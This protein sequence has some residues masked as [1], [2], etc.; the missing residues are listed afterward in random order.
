MRQDEFVEQHGEEAWDRLVKPLK[1]IWCRCDKCSVLR[2]NANVLIH[3]SLKNGESP[4]VYNPHDT[5]HCFN[6]PR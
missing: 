4:L 6:G 1:A 3:A 2:Q 5:S